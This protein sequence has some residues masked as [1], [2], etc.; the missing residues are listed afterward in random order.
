MNEFWMN[1]YQGIHPVYENVNREMFDNRNRCIESAAALR[2]YPPGL[3]PA[4]RLHIKLKLSSG[5]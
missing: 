3:W 1:V 2:H 5:A 4:Y